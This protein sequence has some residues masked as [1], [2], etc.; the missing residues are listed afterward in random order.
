MNW[1]TASQRAQARAQAPLN[2]TQR[3]GATV[4]TA[5]GGIHRLS[6]MD[7][8]NL[9]KE[10]AGPGTAERPRPGRRR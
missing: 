3:D 8:S 1:L 10:K 4:R 9:W 5:G 6:A 7:L 2:A